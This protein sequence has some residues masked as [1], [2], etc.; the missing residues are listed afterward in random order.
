MTKVVP[1]AVT[2]VPGPDIVGVEPPIKTPL[3]IKSAVAVRLEKLQ[4]EYVDACRDGAPSTAILA[5]FKRLG[6]DSRMDLAWRELAAKNSRGDFQYP[7]KY[8]EFR[9]DDRLAARVKEL[10]RRDKALN[11]RRDTLS[12]DYRQNLEV[13]FGICEWDPVDRVRWIKSLAV[14]G[15]ESERIILAA[16]NLAARAARLVIDANPTLQLSKHKGIDHRNDA[17]IEAGRLLE[18]QIQIRDF[19]SNDKTSNYDASVFETL[20]HTIIPAL[21][22]NL[23]ANSALIYKKM[24]VKSVKKMS[25][26]QGPIVIM[27]QLVQTIFGESVNLYSPIAQ[28]L[29]VAYDKEISDVDVQNTVKSATKNV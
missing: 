28:I 16:V 2:N 13:E 20:D 23:A 26:M 15:G 17:I 24:Q 22:H 3:R 9:D 12:M 8:W 11:S 19:L 1:L 18:A 21:K 7:V 27:H 4:A 25:Q 5:A 10:D 29:S 14:I 6:N